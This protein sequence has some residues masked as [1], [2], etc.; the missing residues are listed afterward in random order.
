MYNSI[1]TLCAVACIAGLG[2]SASA[3]PAWQDTGMDAS[4]ATFQELPPNGYATPQQM[5]LELRELAGDSSRMSVQAIGKTH[6][7]TALSMVTLSDGSMGQ[8]RPEIL[9]VANLEGDR[10]VASEVAM[11]LIRHLARGGSPLLE[12][13]RVHVLPMANPDGATHA[14]AGGLPWRGASV[15]EDRDGR[16]DEDGPTDLDGDGKLLWLR[17]PS[18]AGDWHASP[19]DPR[20]SVKAKDVREYAG[21]FHLRREGLDSDGDREF[22][23][24]GAGGIEVDANFAHR[25]KQYAPKAGP[26]P[27]SEPESRAL[28]DF[29]ISHPRIACVL[30]LDDEDNLSKT[31]KGSDKVKIDSTDPMEADAGLIAM[32]AKRLKPEKKSTKDSEPVE[33]PVEI[34]SS[35][36]LL[37]D[38]GNR[39]DPGRYEPVTTEENPKAE[40]TNMP[41]RVAP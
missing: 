9:I 14:L 4:S 13:A 3:A 38:E 23:E 20:C 6:L 21:A 11:G 26:Y 34:G 37:D 28:V 16:A 22:S 27:L 1:R 36:I 18:A 32:L 19:T 10:P 35:P 25:W 39:I 5:A 15:D 7:G 2:G 41:S 17:V 40:V 31:P 30:V 33:E 8:T 24:D 12:V 29:M